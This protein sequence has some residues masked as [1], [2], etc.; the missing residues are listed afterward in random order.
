MRFPRPAVLALCLIFLG[1]MAGCPSRSNVGVGSG[2]SS[3][4]PDAGEA[5]PEDLLKSAIH[6]LRPEN[7]SIASATDKPVNLLNSWHSRTA[8]AG[9]AAE[10]PKIPA[11][12]IDDEDAGQLTRPGYVLPDALHISDAM[13]NHTI[14]TYLAARANDDVGRI[15][16]VFDYVVRNIALRSPDEPDLPLGVYSLQL[17]GRGTAE[18]RAWV[19]AAL[20]RQLR[21]DSVIVRPPHDAGVDDD[22]WLLGILLNGNVHLFDPRMGI[23][24]PSTSDLA[25]AADGRP[26]MLAEIVKHPEWLQSL[27]LRADQPYAIDA[28]SLKHP[29]ILPIV[30][31]GFWSVRMRHLESALPADDLCVLYD[32]LNDEP[33]RTGLLSRLQK[34]SPEWKPGKLTPWSYP[35]HRS[36]EPRQ[37]TQALTARMP[38][39][40]QQEFEIARNTFNIPFPI[41]VNGGKKSLIEVKGMV[42]RGEKVVF[43]PGHPEHKLLR[44][45]TDQLLGKFDDATKRYLSIRHLEIEPPLA[46]VPELEFLNRLGAEN[47]FYWT[48]VCKFEARDFEAAIEQLSKYLQKYDR[49]GRWNFAARALLAECHA[50]LGQFKEAAAA[51]ER[52]RSDDPYRAAN[53]IRIKR[54]T[55]EQ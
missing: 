23:A 4:S 29:E 47:A 31:P 22:A 48:C 36:L 37:Q 44:I 26:A 45:R 54:W 16:M 39:A 10:P 1:A 18:D 49:N 34:L 33:E 35:R 2:N 13:L 28:E 3:G 55:A 20:L 42:D 25:P 19:C 14:A 9:S 51:L 52:S 43:S 46:R 15:R 38:P 8:D 17:F 24:I 5:S 41:L 21:I 27:A 6:Q 11:G 32:P 40:V 7:Y 30:E 50:E 12:W 53:A